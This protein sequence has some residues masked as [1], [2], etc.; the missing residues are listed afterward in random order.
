MPVC[1]IVGAGEGLGQSLAA[2]FAGEG[3]ELGLIS[4]NEAGC[5][6]AM[7][8]ASEARA[9]TKIQH[10]P[11]D[12]TEPESVEQAMRELVQSFGGID[13]LIYNVC[14]GFPACDPLDMTY[15]EMERVFRLE[16]VGAFAAARSV[17]PTMQEQG[18]G[19]IFF[20]SATAALRGSASY[21]LY[22]IGKFGLRALAQSLA[23][24]YA[25]DGL[26]IA[27][28]RLDCDLDVPVM[29]ELY[30]DRYDPETLADP[31]GVA[32]S[33][34]LLHQQPKSAWSNEVELRP[35]TENWTI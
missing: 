3:F 20:S 15:A 7:Q 22:C 4:R 35:H 10:F 14:D 30:G 27:H 2:R 11:A 19:S 32:Q 24:A 16:V 34:W 1:A 26:H 9:D 28:I 25:K 5:K 6:A 23:R 21:P 33:Y 29:R 17:I 8:A 13:I 12:A 18:A 31:D